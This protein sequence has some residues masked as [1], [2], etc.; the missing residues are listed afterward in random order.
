MSRSPA[1]GAT[2][3]KNAAAGP[4]DDS[5]GEAVARRE[6]WSRYWASGVLHSCPGYGE[7]YGGSIARFWHGVFMALPDP[8]RVLDVAT[9]NGAIPRM[10]LEQRRTP[11]VTCDAVDI[12]RVQLPWLAKVDANDRTRVRLH[13]GLDASSLPFPA[14]CFDLIASQYGLEYTDTDRTVPELLR[15]LAPGGAVAMVLHHSQGRPASLAA[16]EIEHGIWL[17]REG[18]WFDATEAM[19]EPMARAATAKGRESLRDD[20]RANAARERFNSLQNELSARAQ[21]GDGADVLFEVRD[22]A[23]RAFEL[24]TRQGAAAGLAAIASLRAEVEAGITRLRDL[25]DHALSEPQARAL[26]ERFANA[27]KKPVA[28]GVLLEERDGRQYVMGWT[29]RVDPGG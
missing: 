12:A 29:L 17:G 4:G 18:G 21:G 5:L 15:V 25:R 13:S 9:G 19:V 3:P 20:V 14:A 22:T 6:A 26:C 28:L 1:P 8:G 7:R 27:L 2:L 11:G 24:A 16:L 23:M 10:L